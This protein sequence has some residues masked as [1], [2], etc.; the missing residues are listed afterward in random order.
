MNIYV[1]DYL[2]EK[3][4]WIMI[5]HN[6]DKPL[7]SDMGIFLMSSNDDT[8]GVSKHVLI[9]KLSYFATNH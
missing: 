6:L 8:L 1:L 7:A 4:I 5:T 2:P 3:P 9:I